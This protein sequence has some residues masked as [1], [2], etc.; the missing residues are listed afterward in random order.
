MGQSSNSEAL[1]G[2][3]HRSQ[4]ALAILLLLLAVSAGQC[5]ADRLTR[6]LLIISTDASMRQE[7]FKPELESPPPEADPLEPAEGPLEELAKTPEGLPEE[8]LEPDMEDIEGMLED[9]EPI[10]G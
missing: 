6:N 2:R 1:Q 3:G 9:F 4:L 7:L 5:A 10:D 8:A